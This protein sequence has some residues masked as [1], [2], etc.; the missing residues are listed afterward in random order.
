M[1]GGKYDSSLTRVR[2]FFGQLIARDATG[3]SWLPQLLQAT[4]RGREVLGSC[5]TQPGDLLDELC[6]SAPSGLMRCFE[7][8]IAAPRALLSWFIEH[9]DELTWP[10]G[11]S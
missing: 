4:P 1:A 3:E 9:P 6:K 5:A 7:Y 10:K 8:P 2:P 11:Q